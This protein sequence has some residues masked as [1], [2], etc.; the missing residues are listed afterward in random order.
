MLS[1]ATKRKKK[2]KNATSQKKFILIAE[3]GPY[4]Y[5]LHV[6]LL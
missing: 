4:F 6:I 1:I 2:Q 5:E 3:T